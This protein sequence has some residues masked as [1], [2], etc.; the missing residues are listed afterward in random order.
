MGKSGSSMA[1]RRCPSKAGDPAHGR[2]ALRARDADGERRSNGADGD[3]CVEQRADSLKAL[4]GGGAQP[5]IGA[6]AAEAL[7][8]DVLEEAMEERFAGEGQG[9]LGVGAGLAIAE[10]DRGRVLHFLV[11]RRS[12]V[13]D[14]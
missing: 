14:R 5:A 8:Q 1:E 12:L 7:G 10:G 13:H 4:L 3:R 6:H 11:G 9:P 2:L